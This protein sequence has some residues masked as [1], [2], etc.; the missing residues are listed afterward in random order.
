MHGPPNPEMRSPAIRQDD[1][2]KSQSSLSDNHSAVSL[3][4]LQAR[5]LCRLFLL[6]PDTARTIA[7]LAYG[8]AR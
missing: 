8:V 7:T 1:R 4:D 3:A 5:A 6:A 2:A